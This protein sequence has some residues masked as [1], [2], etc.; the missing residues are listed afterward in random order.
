MHELLHDFRFSIAKTQQEKAIIYDMRQ[1][2][3]E[4]EATYLLDKGVDGKE[5]A[6]EHS[7]LGVLYYKGVPA[8]CTRAHPYNTSTWNVPAPILA[9]INAGNSEYWL[10]SDRTVVDKPFR[11]QG[12]HAVIFLF[13]LDWTL[14]NTKY[15]KIFSVAKTELAK[16]YTRYQMHIVSETPFSMPDRSDGEYQLSCGDT[17]HVHKAVWQHI[18]QAMSSVA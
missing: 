1:R 11:E 17:E 18:R 5:I 3:Y 15:K 16:T 4:S 9:A 2:N 12:F 8:A 6:D 14:K 13:F 10:Q 7:Y